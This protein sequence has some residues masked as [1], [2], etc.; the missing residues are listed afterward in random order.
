[1]TSD[2]KLKASQ[3]GLEMKD[4]SP[5]DNPRVT[6]ESL[7]SCHSRQPH[8]RSVSHK[9]STSPPDSA[10]SREGMCTRRPR[11]L[12]ADI[13]LQKAA[14]GVWR[15]EEGSCLRRIDFCIT[16]LYRLESNKEEEGQAGTW[17]TDWWSPTAV[18]TSFHSFISA[19]F[20]PLASCVAQH[21][22]SVDHL[23]L[24]CYSRA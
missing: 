6:H 21:P 24:L 8:M 16:Q 4:L 18:C 14:C 12:Q 10:A 9:L 23:L 20:L 2:H 15:G 3:R 5:A 7:I 17:R 19:I 11:S 22:P 13:S 1:M